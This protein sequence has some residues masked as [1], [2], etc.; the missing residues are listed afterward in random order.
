MSYLSI[1]DE[2][3]YESRVCIC[4]VN[5]TLYDWEYEREIDSQRE[6]ERERVCNYSVHVIVI[7]CLASMNHIY[8]SIMPHCTRNI[9]DKNVERDHGER[10]YEREREYEKP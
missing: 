7:D 4:Y 3:V 5:I 6:R 2:S 10:E 9:A 8:I 1:N